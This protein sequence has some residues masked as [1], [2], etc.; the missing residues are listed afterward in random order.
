MRRWLFIALLMSAFVPCPLSAQNAP[1]PPK[2]EPFVVPPGGVTPH[3]VT[4]VPD[5]AEIERQRRAAEEA[6]RR[7]GAATPPN[8]S[9]ADTCVP[10]ATNGN[11]LSC[12]C[13]SR[14]GHLQRTA[15]DFTVCAGHTVVNTNGSLQCQQ[16][17]PR[18]SFSNSC[19]GC[20]TDHN[21]LACACIPAG[22]VLGLL[23]HT[24]IAYAQC[25]GQSV[26][27]RNGNLQCGN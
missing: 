13:K 24:S 3:R 4:P 26:M 6:A 20:S 11:T 17:G 8:G 22:V 19:M 15:I 7:A 12:S 10:C 2:Q 21:T 23:P 18:G 5:P 14:D 16:G 9:Y 25:P 1:A 27:N